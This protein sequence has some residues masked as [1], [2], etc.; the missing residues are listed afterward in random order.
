MRWACWSQVWRLVGAQGR[1]ALVLGVTRLGAAASLVLAAACTHGRPTSSPTTSPGYA[2]F[3]VKFATLPRFRVR[4]LVVGA[5][6]SRRID[7]PV[8][9]WALRTSDGKTILFD[10][11][12]HRQKFIDQW[13]V[14]DFVA[15]DEA[16]RRAGIDPASVTDVILSHIHWDHADGVDLF[17]RAR[18]WLQREEFEYYVG[19]NGESLKPAID[20][21]VAATLRSAM[22]E[23]RVHLIEGSN[24]E[25][26]PGIRVFTGGKHTFASEW[27]AVTSASGPVVL[28][29]DNAYLYENFEKKAAIAQTLDVESNLRAQ[30]AMLELAGTLDRIVPGHDPTVFTRFR[31]AGAGAVRIR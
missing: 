23:G 5:D 9:V 30:A 6:S 17:P 12:F 14:P 3:A 28:A 4:G 16:L 18:V 13:K 21:D 10:S 19:P 25:V 24:V 22:T 1:H 26:L 2:I 20:K 31:A 27:A 7:V 29:S 11:G 8:M 15:P